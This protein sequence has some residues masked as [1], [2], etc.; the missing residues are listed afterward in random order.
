MAH[1]VEHKATIIFQEEPPIGQSL[2]FKL[3][4]IKVGPKKRLSCFRKS[5]G[6][7][8]F[9][10]L[11]ACIVECVSEYIFFVS[12]KKKMQ[13]QKAKET[14]ENRK[15][16]ETNEEREKE[17]VAAVNNVCGKSNGIR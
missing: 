9:H 7:K 3:L 15:I 10:H 12:N 4:S 11:P 5:A 2:I 14:K 8:F 16:K 17:N 13:K 1:C 6:C